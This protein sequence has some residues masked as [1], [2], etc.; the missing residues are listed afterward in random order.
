MHYQRATA[1]SPLHALGVVVLVALSLATFVVAHHVL[2]ASLTHAPSLRHLLLLL[3]R[4]RRL[5]RIQ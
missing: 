3:V 1:A 4:R 5:E 2:S